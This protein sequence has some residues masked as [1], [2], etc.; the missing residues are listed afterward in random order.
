MDFFSL[1]LEIA[2]LVGQCV[3]HVTFVGRLTGK[4]LKIWYF[5]V[6]LLWLCVV[7]WG[8]LSDA[9]AVG[10][11]VLGLFGVCR[12]AMGNR[13]GVSLAAAVFAV[14]ISQLSFGMINSVEA[15][16][17]PYAV[18]TPVLYWLVT[19]A[20]LVSFAVCAG[21]YALVLRA[22]PLAEDGEMP[23][24]G[25][26]LVPGVFFFM[27]E[28]YI[29]HTSYSV[30]PAGPLND[31]G[32]HG[33]LLALQALGLAALICTLYAYRH[34]RRDL[35]AQEE[36]RS[37]EQAAQAQRIYIAE[38]RTRYVQTRAFRHDIANHLAV[39]DGLLGG[40]K[41]DEGRAYL[42]KLKAAS[43]GLAFPAQTGNPVVDI[44]LREKLGAAD[45]LGRCAAMLPQPEI[46]PHLEEIFGPDA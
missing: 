20:V 36:L 2:C 6:Y 28:L 41:W 39:L 17:F 32:K 21:C 8:R 34:L 35:R 43:D 13:G 42:Q 5:A 31:D 38:A 22:L 15:M 18:G 30:L 12:G 27:A 40:G 24:V 33:G 9:V 37:L 45:R 4:K 19:A 11:E 26:L 14:Y 7:E 3:A 16:V 1:A 29:L 46:E 23:F 10:V 44:L 25:V